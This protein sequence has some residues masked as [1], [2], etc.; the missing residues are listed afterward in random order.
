V[1][2]EAVFGELPVDVQHDPVARDLGDDRRGR[3]RRAAGVA[4]HQVP[5]RAGEPAQRDEIGD[6]QIRSHL[7]LVQR[8]QHGHP[9]RLQD[10]D[11]VDR[12]VI[13]DADADRDRAR[14]D[15]VVE[16]GAP[17]RREELGIGQALDAAIGIDD[18]GRR[19]DRPGQRPAAGLVHPGHADDAGAPGSSLE[20]IRR[21]RQ[22]HGRGRPG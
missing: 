19:D 7:E 22:R 20:V 21:R 16:L 14:H 10:V 2:G 1:P 11:A 17:L 4:V 3:H 6:D 15:D 9:G 13:D 18:D 12:D 5:L 8:L